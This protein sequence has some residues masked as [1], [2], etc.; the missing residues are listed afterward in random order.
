MHKSESSEVMETQKTKQNKKPTVRRSF[1]SQVSFLTT[2]SSASSLQPRTSMKSSPSRFSYAAPFNPN[3]ISTPNMKDFFFF[4]AVRGCHPPVP[5]ASWLPRIARTRSRWRASLLWILI[6]CKSCGAGRHR[7]VPAGPPR[8]V[9]EETALCPG[10]H[11][12][13]R[14]DTK[15]IIISSSTYLLLSSSSQRTDLFQDCTL[16]C[17]GAIRSFLNRSL[18]CLEIIF[19]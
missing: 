8:A 9:C 14:L 2:S 16:Q 11:R 1:S 6:V 19:S 7:W 18:T 17:V 13:S 4:S 15:S 12:P 10:V 3:N 5:P